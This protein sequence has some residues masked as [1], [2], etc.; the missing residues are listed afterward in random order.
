MHM[1]SSAL[2]L[3]TLI[4]RVDSKTISM[5]LFIYANEVVAK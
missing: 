4:P 2:A 1:A 3:M 5:V